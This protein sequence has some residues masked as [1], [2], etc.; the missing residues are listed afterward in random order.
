MMTNF[1]LKVRMQGFN[2][3][4]IDGEVWAKLNSLSKKVKSA[5]IKTEIFNL[6]RLPDNDI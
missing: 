5:E 6:G 1:N 4:S 3:P 2:F